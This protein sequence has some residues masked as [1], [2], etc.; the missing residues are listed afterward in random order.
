MTKADHI[1]FWKETAEQEWSSAQV[2]FTAGNYL[3]SLF[4]A[5]LV[6]EKLSKA[7]WVQD[8]VGDHPPRIHNIVKLWQQTTLQPTPA[9]E[10]VAL[11]LNTFQ[12][13]GRY[14]DYQRIAYQRATESFTRALL[15]DVAN[16]RSWLLST[17]P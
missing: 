16:L 8:N 5:H 9:Q 10:Q 12:L 2:L 14:Q 17:L 15:Q 3:N 11:N 7:H 6:I 1:L 13:E 4:M